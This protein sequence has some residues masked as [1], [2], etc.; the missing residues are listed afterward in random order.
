MKALSCIVA[1]TALAGSVS[2]CAYDYYSYPRYGY[3]QG[4]SYPSSYS[5][6]SY[7]SYSYSYPRYGYAQPYYGSSY[8][9]SYPSYPRS[10]Y[11]GSYWD[12]QRN[13]QGIHSGPEMSMA[14]NVP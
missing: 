2:G 6:Y 14:V 11:Y 4:Y 3:S 13:Y 8:A 9:Y 12:Y 7:P 10:S 1:A 5:Y